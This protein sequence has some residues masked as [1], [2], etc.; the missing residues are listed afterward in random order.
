MRDE[1]TGNLF[2]WFNSGKENMIEGAI[3]TGKATIK[4][5]TEYKDKKFTVITRFKPVMI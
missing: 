2:T 3:Y 1:E 5:H 4:K